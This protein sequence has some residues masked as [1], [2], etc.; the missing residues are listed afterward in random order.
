VT[1]VVEN[2]LSYKKYVRS[3]P[4]PARLA[5]GHRR[6]K[7]SQAG[8]KGRRWTQDWL[9][10]RMGLPS[11]LTWNAHVLAQD[12]DPLVRVMEARMGRGQPPGSPLLFFC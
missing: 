6:V 7:L 9:S 1:A 4:E 5:P 2:R 3:T 12:P 11:D 10:S 8:S